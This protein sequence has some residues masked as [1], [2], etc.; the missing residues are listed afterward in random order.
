MGH[1]PSKQ[2]ITSLLELKL[3]TVTMFEWQRHSQDSTEVPDCKELLE[4][5][6]QRAQAAEASNVDRKPKNSH[7]GVKPKTIPTFTASTRTNKE[8]CKACKKEKHPLYSCSKFRSFSH[9]EKTALLKSNNHCLNCLRS[10]WT[11]CKRLQ[12]VA[13]L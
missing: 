5:I 13:S 7:F 8:N 11:L 3:D 10:F 1:E 12:I 4:F 2:F 9:E 6:D